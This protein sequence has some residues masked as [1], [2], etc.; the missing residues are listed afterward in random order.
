LKEELREKENKRFEAAAEQLKAE[1]AKSPELKDLQNNILIDI[2]PE[3][4][5]I[6]IV[7]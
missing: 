7:V 5:R 1:I 6:Q 2:T 3:G 4:L